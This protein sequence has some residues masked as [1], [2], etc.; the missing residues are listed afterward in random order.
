[1]AVVAE[2]VT[3][4]TVAEMVVPVD[5]M[6]KLTDGVYS[7]TGQGNTPPFSPPQG[8]NGGSSD[9]NPGT[10]G[11]AGGGGGWCRWW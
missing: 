9:H 2:E 5:L 10:Y 4:L 3:T 1:M 6:I 8:N 7:T 11:M